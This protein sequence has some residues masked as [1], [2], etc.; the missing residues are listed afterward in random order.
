MINVAMDRLMIAGGGGGGCSFGSGTLCLAED[1]VGANVWRSSSIFDILSSMAL[2]LAIRVVF[3]AEF[4]LMM[5]TVFWRCAKSSFSR[6][7]IF[8]KR[9]PVES[10]RRLLCIP[11]GVGVAFALIALWRGG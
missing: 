4:W 10:P 3:S 11:E 9:M 1:G 8:S 2:L 5:V 6:R 7:V